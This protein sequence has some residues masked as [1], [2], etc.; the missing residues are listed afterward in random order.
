[1]NRFSHLLTTDLL[2]GNLTAC[3]TDTGS[4]SRSGKCNDTGPGLWF[5]EDLWVIHE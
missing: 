4:A 1:M 2:C 5:D 3:G